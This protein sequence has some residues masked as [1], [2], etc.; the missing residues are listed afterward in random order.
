MHSTTKDLENRDLEI[1]FLYNGSN[2]V[3]LVTNYFIYLH[4]PIR[5]LITASLT[6]VLVGKECDRIAFPH[7]RW[8]HLN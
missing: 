8:S 7:N 4:L 5:N 6:G 1:G 2:L 3:E